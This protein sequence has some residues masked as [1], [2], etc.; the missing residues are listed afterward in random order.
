MF[1]E[2]CAILKSEFELQLFYFVLS[3]DFLCKRIGYYEIYYVVH[4]YTVYNT[5]VDPVGLLGNFTLS[6]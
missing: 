4:W 1:R 6:T 3:V 2:I 5:L